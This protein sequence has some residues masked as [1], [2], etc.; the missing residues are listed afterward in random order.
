MRNLSGIKKQIGFTLIEILVALMIFS[1]IGVAINIGLKTVITTNQDLRR[2]IDYFDSL[3]FTEVLFAR[4]VRN[5][6]PYLRLNNIDKEIPAC[7]GSD[8]ELSIVTKGESLFRVSYFVKEHELLREVESL[9]F[10]STPQSQSL[11]KDVQRI[12]LSYRGIDNLEYK[13]WPPINKPANYLPQAIKLRVISN[14]GRVWQQWYT[15]LYEQAS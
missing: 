1:I 8:K 3:N 5:I 6:I 4:D 2:V 12:E 11:A 14:D 15:L 13:Q 9:F 7:K 10:K